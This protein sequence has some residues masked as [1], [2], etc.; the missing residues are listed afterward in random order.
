MLSFL[1]KWII[2]LLLKVWNVLYKKWLLLG[3]C[4]IIF[5][6]GCLFVIL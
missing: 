5:F 4:L 1:K 2:F 6:V 3:I